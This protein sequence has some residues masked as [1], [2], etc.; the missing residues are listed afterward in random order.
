M[1]LRDAIQSELTVALQRRDR[2]VASALRTALAAIANAE[3]APGAAALDSTVGSQHFAGATAGLGATEV[4]RLTLTEEQQRVIVTREQA[5]LTAH[6]ER[7]SA[8]CR[9]DDA[10]QARR[11]ADA[12]AHALD[13]AR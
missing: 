3:A 12:L 9:H 1:A 4:E 8:L 11:A 7:L 6:A 5:E 13:Q 2:P 10:T